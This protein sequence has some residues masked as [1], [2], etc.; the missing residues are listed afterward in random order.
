MFI[1]RGVPPQWRK[2]DVGF[3]RWLQWT[4]KTPEIVTE[5]DL[6]SIRTAEELLASTTSSSFP[7]TPS[8]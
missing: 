6:E 8:T 1:R 5:T 3:L 2:Y 4:S 7:A